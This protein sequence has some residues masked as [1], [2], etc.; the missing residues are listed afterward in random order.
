MISLL[1]VRIMQGGCGVQALAGLP[2]SLRLARV[3]ILSYSSEN[4]NMM[5]VRSTMPV[6]Q[7]E[8]MHS[9]KFRLV[10]AVL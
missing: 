10:N 1:C 6:P 2:C 9:W 8:N 3:F 7:S 4:Q 5:H